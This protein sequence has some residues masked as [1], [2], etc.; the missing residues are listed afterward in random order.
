MCKQNSDCEDSEAIF[1]VAILFAS[2][3]VF[4]TPDKN[5]RQTCL[6]FPLALSTH[7]CQRKA[8]AAAFSSF[9]S[10]ICSAALSLSDHQIAFRL[11]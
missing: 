2:F 11:K 8:L 5:A 4:Q 1:A 3:A 6:A 10:P 9:R 7:D